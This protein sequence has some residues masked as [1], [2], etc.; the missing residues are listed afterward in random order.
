MELLRKCINAIIPYLIWTIINN[1]KAF[2]SKVSYIVFSFHLQK[3]DL[4]IVNHL[5]I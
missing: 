4:C 1:N 2:L 3:S 5:C